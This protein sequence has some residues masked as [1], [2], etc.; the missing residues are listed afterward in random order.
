MT[1]V[2][3]LQYVY[4]LCLKNQECVESQTSHV[5]ILG[6]DKYSVRLRYFTVLLDC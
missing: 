4:K 3:K 5:E 2:G 1:A 6:K